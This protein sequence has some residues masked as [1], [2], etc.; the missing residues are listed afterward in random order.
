MEI[1]GGCC[2]IVVGKDCV[3]MGAKDS[4]VEVSVIVLWL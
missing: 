1:V 3:L 4:C 2:V